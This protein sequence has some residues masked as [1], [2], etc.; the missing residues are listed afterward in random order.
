MAYTKPQVIAQNNSSGSYAAGCP[1]NQN[2]S[3]AGWGT[4]SAPGQRQCKNCERTA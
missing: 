2:A 3:G 1:A 4:T